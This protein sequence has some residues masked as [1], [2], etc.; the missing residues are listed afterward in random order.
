MKIVMMTILGLVDV[1]VKCDTS[2]IKAWTTTCAACAA[3]RNTHGRYTEEQD[4]TAHNKSKPFPI[5]LC[6][7]HT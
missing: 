2:R 7:Y 6:E 5:P 1:S 3:N 4:G